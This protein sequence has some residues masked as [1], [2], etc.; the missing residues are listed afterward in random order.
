[1]GEVGKM[2]RP[3][4][5]LPVL[6]LVLASCRSE[7]D[8]GLDAEPTGPPEASASISEATGSPTPSA[9]PGIRTD[10]DL[11][12]YGELVKMWDYNTSEPLDY[13]L[14]S[15]KRR[16]DGV[17][18]Y[19]IV[20]PSSGFAVPAYLVMPEGQGPF[21]AVVYA[22]GYGD[23]RS[24]FLDDAVALARRGVAGLVIQGPGVLREPFV[25]MGMGDAAED[26]QGNQQYLIDLRRGID[27]LQT[28]SQLDASR[29]G[30]VGHSLGCQVGGILSGVEDRIDAYVLMS[31][32]GYAT[33]PEWSEFFGPDEELALYQDQIAVLNPVDYIAHSQAT[34]FL[35]QASRN[36]SYGASVP[37][38][39]A[40]FDAAPGTKVL[41]GYEGGHALGCVGFHFC[42]SD[43]PAFVDHRA[44]LREKV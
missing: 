39:R 1:L 24:F 37:N 14:I 10:F 21:P 17:T 29:I 12:P 26:I 28:L 23:D 13:E 42:D 11:P 33:D 4:L 15:T 22:H 5:F 19:D 25:T 38:I 2:R 40:L 44:W 36:D 35:I 31:C 9:T 43:L 34:A 30:F 18:K 8:E 6:A 41:R 7:T 3:I 27:L 20:Y 32:V 16:R